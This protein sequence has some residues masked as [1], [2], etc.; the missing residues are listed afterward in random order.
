VAVKEFSIQVGDK[1]L[2]VHCRLV[3]PGTDGTILYLSYRGVP[4]ATL[5]AVFLFSQG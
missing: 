5:G 2:P 4:L 1:F 3:D